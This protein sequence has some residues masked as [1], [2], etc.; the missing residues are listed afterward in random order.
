MSVTVILPDNKRLNIK[1]TI[2]TLLSEVSS[3]LLSLG[4]DDQ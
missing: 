1:V 3:T 4:A 2:N